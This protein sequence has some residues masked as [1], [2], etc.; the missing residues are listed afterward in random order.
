MQDQPIRVDLTTNRITIGATEIQLPRQEAELA[1]TLAKEMPRGARKAQIIIAL[2]GSSE[3][4]DPDVHIR[5][6]VC[7]LRR[8]LKAHGIEIKNIVDVG[9]RM[10]LTESQ[11]IRAMRHA[12]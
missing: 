6:V 2:W 8:M 1:Y 12:A 7:R 10:V 3:G 5:V 9:Y 4:R 11:P